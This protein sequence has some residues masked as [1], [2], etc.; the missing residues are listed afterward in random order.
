M[1]PLGDLLSREQ[2]DS[3][4]TLQ[5]VDL[6]ATK[7]PSRHTALIDLVYLR[8]R[9]IE[10][11]EMND[12][13]RQA[14]EKLDAIVEKLRSPAFRVG[15]FILPVEPDKCLVCVGGSDYVCRIDP[16]LP[17]ASFQI[18]QRILCNEAFNVVQGL[19]FDKNGPIVRI[20]EL[21][22]DGRLRIG[23]E[24][25]L[26]SLVVIRSALL[27]KEKLKPGMDIRLDANQRV[28]L[29]VLGIGKR[30]ERSLETVIKTPWEVIGGQT[31]AVSAIRET[32]E[33]PFLYRDLFKKFQHTVP[34]GFLLYGP[35]GCGKTLLGKA[36]AYN[37]R[38]QL[39]DRTGI[40]HPEF[41]LHV[42]G[43]EILNMWVGESERQV[44]DLFSQ[45]RERAS[46]GALAFLFIDEAES[47]LG[48]RRGGRFS[49]I[50]ST[51]V[52]MFCTEMDGLEALNNVVVILAS[53]RADLIDPA[54][55]RP[56]R[57]D[58]K[59][60]VNRPDKD[61]ALQIYE[62]YLREE[63]P[64]AEP[65]EQLAKVVRDAHYAK[66]EENQ[67][68]EIVYRSGKKDF[69]YRG[70]MSS[71]AIIAAIVER[72]KGIAIK[73]AIESGKDTQLT[74]DDLLESLQKEYLENDLFPPTDITEDWLKLT[75]FD[76]ENVI[77]LGPIRPRK[78][79]MGKGIV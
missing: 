75:D 34:K 54:I 63:L 2:L 24:S 66:S 72:A 55:L 4:S 60:K 44:R 69:L 78:S 10:L 3:L 21:L 40:D 43:P 39:K 35:P 52:P 12:Q 17:L 23:Q 56:G 25:G 31:E 38:Q 62:I 41:F 27:A 61:G 73:R 7:L 53:N 37:L 5:L 76:P 19:G 45:C 33:F 70:D 14:I 29:E 71:G 64:L 48:T 46:D 22:S 74:R 6:I 79:E 15:T 68:L 57:I 11:E 49:N 32:I 51:L 20:D 18:G 13:A 58:R 47:I 50:L 16:Q 59:I 67:F 28:A 26:S 36:T 30:I 42:K 1:P 8:D 77:K 65:R 9:I